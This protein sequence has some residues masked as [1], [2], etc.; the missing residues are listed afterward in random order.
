MMYLSHLIIYLSIYA[1][2][3]SGL[4][5]ITGYCGLFSLAHAAF[6]A[7]GAYA[8]S[9]ASLH[10]QLGAPLSFLIAVAIATGFSLFLSVPSR[11]AGGDFFVLVSLVV[12][13]LTMSAFQNAAF[14]GGMLGIAS[15]PA[16]SFGPWVLG[17]EQ[18]IAVVY[19][20]IAV[21]ILCL[22]KV[23]TSS[24]WSRILVCMREDELAVR[25]LGKS[26]WKARA[27]AIAIGCGLAGGAGAMFVAYTS[28][29]NPEAA[30]LEHSMLF[31]SM[32][33]VGG[34]GNLR[35][36]LVGVLFTLLLPEALRLVEVPSV[37]ISNV[38]LIIYGLLLIVFMHLRPEGLAGRY[39]LE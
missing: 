3:V 10:F 23:L 34:S 21:I 17:A 11:R 27:E 9:L 28:F 18:S 22:L 19:S 1:I 36:P 26:T 4:N 20:S 7:I 30:S 8:Y 31:L 16:P 24:P 32:L 38:R 37:L 33:L 15:V 13:M 29:I 6:F 14:S 5:L 35:G 25:S 39:R 12:Q 2:A